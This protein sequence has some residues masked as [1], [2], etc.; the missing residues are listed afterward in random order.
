MAR[1]RERDPALLRSYLEGIGDSLVLVEDDS[2]IK[3]HV[4]TDAPGRA[5]N[6]ALRY[7]QEYQTLVYGVVLLAVI[8]LLPR[9]I[10]GEI[11][12]RLNARK[13]GKA[14]LKGVNGNA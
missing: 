13:A 14:A 4:H 6:E 2:I 5:L 3:G 1:E 7:A 10:V 12:Q 11:A 8:L 9:G